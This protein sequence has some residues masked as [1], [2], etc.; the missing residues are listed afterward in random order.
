ML[1]IDQLDFVSATSGRHPDF[2]D[3]LAALREEVLGLR[4][5]HTIHLILACRKFDFEHDHRLKQLITK[6]QPPVQLGEFDVEE[7]KSVVEKE[8]GDLARLTPQQQS[9][10]RLPQNLSLFVDARLA[11]AENRFT[12]PKEL[13]DAYWTT[14]RKSVSAVRAE[15]GNYWLPAIKRLSSSMSEL[16]QLSVPANL[17]DEIPP[18]FLE[19]MAS[20]GV[21]TWDGKRCGFGHETFFDYCFARTLPNGGRDFVHFLERD[22]QHLFRRAQ[23][24]QVLAF[25]RDDDFGAYLTSIEKLLLSDKIRPHLKLLT[26]ELV[27]AHPQARDEELD[28]LVPWIEVEMKCRREGRLNPDKL[29]SRI[30]DRFFASRTLFLA[31]DRTGLINRWL[32]SDE[33]WLQDTMALYLR[34]Q[35]EDHA[36]RIAE[37]LEPF[38]EEPNG[39]CDF[40]T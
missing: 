37:L 29:A 6:D 39:A 7:V 24:R 32:N 35:T 11:R 23:L 28:L 40:V 22:V 9:M 38:V 20:E 27:A 31:A 12:T 4:L 36:E 15:F 33:A 21:I 30:W 26:V 13:C 1:V 25:L 3:T 10:L 18:D 16:Q 8:G 34:W 2:F 19:T 17:M 14:K 5:R